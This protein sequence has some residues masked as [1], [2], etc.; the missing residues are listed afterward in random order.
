MTPNSEG[1]ENETKEKL[2]LIAF[3][4]EDRPGV[5]ARVTGLLRRRNFN[6]TQISV[7]RTHIKNY[8]RMTFIVQGDTRT[9]E[10]VIK[11]LRK[12]VE[13]LKVSELKPET[14]VARELALVKVKSTDVTSR[15]E[16]IQFINI[17]R[18]T[19][20]DVSPSSLI[21]EVT[22]DTKKIDAFLKLLSPFGIIEVARTGT[23]ALVRGAEA[24]PKIPETPYL[25]Y[26]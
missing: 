13:V 21:C 3:V 17:F 14:S 11:Q 20:I 12:Q 4:V 22:G 26:V 8:T 15:N 16:I 23:T 5:M 24:S 7:A 9:L 1:N 25:E 18:G 2:H 10:Q 19:I 6:I